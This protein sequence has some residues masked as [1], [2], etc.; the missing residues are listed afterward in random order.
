MSISRIALLALIAACTLPYAHAATTGTTQ[1][2]PDG[3]APVAAPTSG[4]PLA[5]PGFES[6]Q[7][8][9]RGDPE[10]WFTFQHAGP[11]SYRYVIDT[12]RPHGGAR[13]LRIEN[14]GPEPYGAVAQALDARPHVGKTAKLTGWLRTRDANDAGAGLTLLVMQGGATVGYN[15]Q[16]D[17]PVNGTTDWKRYS[18]SVAI[19]R[20]A[21]RL[22]IGAMMRG[23]GALWLDDV[24]LEFVAP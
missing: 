20:G 2:T 18:I 19:P 5:N 7:T 9:S 10:G 13:S 14:I 23:K 15:F 21:D 8:G 1:T 16:Y 4:V 12:E 11:P 17:A 3:K 6:A 24:A 22:E